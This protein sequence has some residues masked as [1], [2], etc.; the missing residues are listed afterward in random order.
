MNLPGISTARRPDSEAEIARLADLHLKR[1]GALGRLPTPLDDLVV[2]AGLLDVTETETFKE[3]FLASLPE[4]ARAAF[5]S[6]WQKV[7]GI[8]DLRERAVFVPKTTSLPRVL[9]ATGH[10]LGHQVLPWQKVNTAFLDDEYSLSPEAEELF[11]LEANFFAA[12]LIFQGRRFTARVRDYKPSFDAVFVLADEHGASRH[13]TLRR[14]VEEHDEIIALVPYS[15]SRYSLDEDG[16]P[17]LR[18]WAKVVGS[19]RFVQ[20]YSGIQLPAEIR[21]GHPWVAS[22][23]SQQVEEGEITLPCGP[24]TG[25]VRFQWQS[26]W[27]TYSLLVLLR[28]R[29]VLG[30]VGGLIR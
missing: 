14:Y 17:T 15:P 11:D 1:A 10:E 24:G 22:R 13:A 23:D 26:W 25:A 5:N 2:A 7:R 3:A 21:S 30:V 8:A 28:R 29:P 27:N 12:E 19:P 20:R 4:R 16:I 6:T 18:R 9:F